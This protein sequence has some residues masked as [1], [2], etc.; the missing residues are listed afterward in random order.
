MI[1]LDC[2]C[3]IITDGAA[4]NRRQALALAEALDR[5][6]R[7]IDVSL[8]PPWKW[9]SPHWLAGAPSALRPALSPPW[10]A[11]V[12]G[13][14]RA[15]AVALDALPKQSLGGP[16]R[17]QILNPRC[18]PQR[19]DRVIAPAHD[20]LEGDNVHSLIGSLHSITPAWLAAA[21]EQSPQWAQSPGPRTLLLIGGRR[22]QVGFGAAALRELMAILEHWQS[23]D[24]GS[25]W[26]SLSRRTPVAWRTAIERHLPKL[27][28]VQLWR[29]T[30]DGENPYRSWIAW[31]DRIV[32]TPD[33]VNML[34]EACATSKPVLTHAPRGVGGRLGELHRSLRDSGRLR[35]LRLDYQPWN[36][37]PLQECA[38]IADEIA[39]TL[40]EARLR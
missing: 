40:I 17:I 26:I 8:R 4:G 29:D 38:R 3:W 2:D 31:A 25:L 18:P 37:A 33:S 30:G 22:R 23:R 6:A 5:R 39:A 36:Y 9:L 19:F 34:S 7:L 14:G 24:E 13:C 20:A 21:R 35:P 15:G 12:I 1:A 11:L 28:Q 16:L 32:V 10:P 27:G